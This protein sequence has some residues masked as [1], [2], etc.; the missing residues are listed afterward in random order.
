MAFHGRRY[1]SS[2]SIEDSL[3][4]L[5]DSIC[6]AAD[7]TRRS[8]RYMTLDAF[9]SRVKRV[10]IRREFGFHAVTAPA[11]KLR[12]LHVLD[13]PIGDLSPYND[14]ENSHCPNKPCNA[15]QGVFAIKAR[16]AQPLAYLPLA[17]EE[18]DGDQCQSGKE[19]QREYE[20]DHDSNVG[21]VHVPADLQWQHKEPRDD[22]GR[23]KSD[24]DQTYPVPSQQEPRG[25]FRCVIHRAQFVEKLRRVRGV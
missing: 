8:G 22:R 15:S 3:D 10:L 6:L 23:K 20:K 4:Q 1:R 9:H 21:I 11:A 5:P 18:S 14:V 17:E 12:G 25:P 24:P 19:D 7:P 2:V 16:F 13:G